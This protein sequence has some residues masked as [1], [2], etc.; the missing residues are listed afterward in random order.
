MIRFGIAQLRRLSLLAPVVLATTASAFGQSTQWSPTRTSRPT[1]LTESTRSAGGASSAGYHSSGNAEAAIR[2]A[3]YTADWQRRPSTTASNSFRSERPPVLTAQSNRRAVGTSNSSSGTRT[4]AA[5]YGIVLKEGEQ[6]EGE[7]RITEGGRADGRAD[8]L[9]V[10]DGV[11]SDPM[12]TGGPRMQGEVVHEGEMLHEGGAFATGDVFAGEGFENDGHIGCADGVAGGCASGNCGSGNCGRGGCGD[13][14]SNCN[15]DP[16]ADP[17]ACPECG[18]FGYHRL[19]CGRVAACLENCLGPLIREWSV[20]AGTQA[21]KGPIDLGLNGNFGFNEGMNTAGPIIPFPRFGL[22]W[23][24]GGRFTQSDLSGNVF[25]TNTREQQFLTAGVFH[26][27]YRHRGLQWGVVYDW[28]SENYY[29]KNSLSQIR[30]EISFLNG[31]GHELGFL[32]TQGIREETNDVFP[33]FILRPADQ[34]NLFYR[35]TTQTGG[36]GRLWGGV[37]GQ[38]LGTVGADFRVPMSNRVDFVG[39]FNY[40]APDNGQNGGGQM[41]ESWGLGMNIVWYFGRRKEGVHN[42]PFRPLF[43]VADNGSFMLD[44]F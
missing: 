29:T 16:W 40:I 30:A 42:T 36:Q 13:G 27:A 10:P 35:Y 34:Y 43:N 1:V 5:Q 8:V 41:D 31:C 20:F 22:G 9:P 4:V 21:F 6:L 7:P 14:C 37:T 33:Q 18:V 11:S 3:Q 28:L 23:Q 17:C 24:I 25:G 44:R 39:G 26:R 32:G 19:G 15:R 12:T 2:R 38:G